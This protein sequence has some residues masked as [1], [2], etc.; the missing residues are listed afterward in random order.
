[1]SLNIISKEPKLKIIIKKSVILER[2]D[3]RYNF[4]F[5]MIQSAKIISY[6]ENKIN[7]ILPEIM[8]VNQIGKKPI[9]AVGCK[10]EDIAAYKKAI[11]IPTLKKNE[12]KCIW[13]S[14][15]IVYSTII[16][17]VIPGFE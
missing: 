17:P 7:N 12:T 5:D 2:I 15:S 3:A 14:E 13:L 9:Q 10:N 1:M 8:F 6:I 16:V 11:A 4:L